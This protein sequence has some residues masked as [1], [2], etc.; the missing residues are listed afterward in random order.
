MNLDFGRR[1]FQEVLALPLFVKDA[2]A[3]PCT[4]FAR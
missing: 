2:D 4:V 1:E 3:F